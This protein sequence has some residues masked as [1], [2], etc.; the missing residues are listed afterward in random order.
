MSFSIFKCFVFPVNIVNNMCN[1]NTFS[2]VIWHWLGLFLAP[3]DP[4]ILDKFSF[5]IWKSMTLDAVLP[6]IF[7]ESKT[8]DDEGSEF[9]INDSMSSHIF[10][11]LVAL[12]RDN[13]TVPLSSQGELGLIIN[14]IK[15]N[16]LL[17]LPFIF[18]IF[19]TSCG[20]GVHWRSLPD[21]LEFLPLQFLPSFWWATF[22]VYHQLVKL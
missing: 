9:E 17:W 15:L 13:F 21:D 11:T 10:E 6:Y 4:F 20:V 2:K 18:F 22:L 1:K 5:S 8:Y 16:K 12:T 3:F 7:N 14:A 19:A